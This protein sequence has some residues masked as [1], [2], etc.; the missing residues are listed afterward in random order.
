MTALLTFPMSKAA[1][2][3]LTTIPASTN[4]SNLREN[5]KAKVVLPPPVPALSMSITAE[6]SG[7][8]NSMI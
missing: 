6:K 1:D 5:I 2:Y 4:D 8:H 3:G 7:S